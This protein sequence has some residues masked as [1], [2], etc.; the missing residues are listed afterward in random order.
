MVLSRGSC[1]GRVSCRQGQYSRQEW[2]FSADVIV[3]NV[4]G[5][6][7]ACAVPWQEWLT[8]K[9]LVNAVTSCKREII[10]ENVAC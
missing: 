4:A 3:E 6:S 9:W 7:C 10:Q 2:W 8:C 5:M 1:R